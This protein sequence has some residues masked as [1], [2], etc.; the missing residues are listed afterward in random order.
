M[1]VGAFWRGLHE[2]GY[3]EGQNFLVET[4]SA[5]GDDRRLP[6]LAADLTAL[7]PDVIVT[8]G[9]LAIRAVKE[10]AG[11]IPIVMAVVDDLVRLG[12]AQSLAHPGG[13]LTGLSIQAIDVLG[14]RLQLLHETIPDAGCVAVL[15]RTGGNYDPG[16]SPGLAAAARELGVALLPISITSTSELPAGFA[17]MTR[18][19]CR[20]LL[21][22]SVPGFVDARQQ[23]V[24]LSLQH[25]IAASYDNK[26]IVDAGGLMSY[27]P[28]TID[29]FRRAAVFVD[30]ILKGKQASD[31]P[32]EQPTQFKMVINL[33]T[34]KTLGLTIP[35]SVL[36]RADEVIE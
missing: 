20:S 35:Q 6:A 4:R 12:F 19:H 3:V 16:A 22:M 13:N 15:G 14:K 2:L 18:H 34:A 27:G 23:L 33:K 30:K 17:K 28:D 10:F 29:M 1:H 9:E 31:L 8:Y 11:S 5:E 36:A 21:A 32:I 25:G 26:L 24:E 7:K